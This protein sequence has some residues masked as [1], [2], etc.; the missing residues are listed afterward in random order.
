MRKRLMLAVAL[1]LGAVCLAV[2]LAAS[3]KDD[4][5]VTIGVRLDFSATPVVG[6][7][8]ACCAI[9]DSGTAS[10]V[11]TKFEPSGSEAQFEA[12][13][14]FVGSEG[15]FTIM[16]RGVTGP[17]GSPVHIAEGRWSVIDGTGGYADLEGDGR[18]EATTDQSTGALTA[19]DTGRVSREDD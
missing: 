11:V 13:N 3:G 14:T 2:P 6:T 17:L 1:A 16:L 15:S 10:A 7:F 18:F 4:R 5:G 19:I 12:T 9:T 8:A